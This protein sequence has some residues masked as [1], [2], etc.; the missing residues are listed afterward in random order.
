MLV[1]L[2][3]VMQ[4]QRWGRGQGVKT[5]VDFPEY[6]FCNDIPLIVRP[7]LVWVYNPD[8]LAGKLIF[9]LTQIGRPSGRPG[10]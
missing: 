10:G 8:R 9:L 5:P 7:M 4:I 3:Y 6:G 1:N 2:D